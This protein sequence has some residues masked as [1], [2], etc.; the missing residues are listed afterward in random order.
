MLRPDRLRAFCVLPYDVSLGQTKQHRSAGSPI[1][2]VA[3]ATASW[4]AESSSR[5]LALL[6]DHERASC[7]SPSN[8]LGRTRQGSELGLASCP[9][10]VLG[11]ES[12]EAR[13]RSLSSPFPVWETGNAME[14]VGLLSV[15]GHMGVGASTRG[16]HPPRDASSGFR[17]QLEPA[18]SVEHAVGMGWGKPLS[19]F[20]SLF[21][22]A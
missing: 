19:S 13:W 4:C 8:C 20:A 9:G 10:R 1:A 7:S 12:S 16:R 14:G 3:R 18:V 15:P 11:K 6:Q 17:G 2:A 21:L 22:L 5:G